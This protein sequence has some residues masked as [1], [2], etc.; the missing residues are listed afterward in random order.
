MD[1]KELLQLIFTALDAE[2]KRLSKLTGEYY[3]KHEQYLLSDVEGDEDTADDFFDSMMA[4]YRILEGV[5]EA[6]NIVLKVAKENGI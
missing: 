5:A 3:E 6:E 2:K 1:N 4:T